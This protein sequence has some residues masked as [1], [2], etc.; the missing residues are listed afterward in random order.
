VMHFGLRGAVYGMLLSGATYC[1][2]LTIGFWFK[3]YNKAPQQA[4]QV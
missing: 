1:S 3:V 2:T 4:C